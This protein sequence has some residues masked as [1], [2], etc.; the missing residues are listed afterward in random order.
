MKR[1]LATS[2]VVLLASVAGV[3]AAEETRPDAATG[4]GDQGGHVCTPR[5]AQEWAGNRHCGGRRRRMRRTTNL[6]SRIPFG[7]DQCR[8]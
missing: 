4:S 8:T 7:G 2:I 5:I 1:S 3:Q 6:R